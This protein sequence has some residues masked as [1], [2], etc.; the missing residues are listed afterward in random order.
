M[1]TNMSSTTFTCSW[2]TN[3][4]GSTMYSFRGDYYHAAAL[5]AVTKLAININFKI[6]YLQLADNIRGSTVYSSRGPRT[7]QLHYHQ[8]NLQ[9]KTSST[10][11]IPA[12]G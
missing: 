2:L 12:A 7:M 3:T 8:T 11:A 1:Q 9:A 5:A 4:R 6:P 10:T